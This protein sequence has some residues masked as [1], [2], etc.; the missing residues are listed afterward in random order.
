MIIKPI[1]TV[2]FA[3]DFQA[4]V[5]WYIETFDLNPIYYEGMED[6]YVDLMSGDQCIVGITA[7]NEADKPLHLPRRS[8][9]FM[10]ISSSHM[11]TLF[12]RVAETGGKVSFGPS[13][14]VEYWY[15]GLKDPENNRIWV[16][17]PNEDLVEEI[18]EVFK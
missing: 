11:F 15:G 13:K 17:T 14:E 18:P 4:M 7:Y 2:I 5:K 10:Q 12:Q 6:G 9:T 3:E 1:N 16:Y 8:A